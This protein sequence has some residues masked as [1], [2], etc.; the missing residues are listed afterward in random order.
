M[1][2]AAWATIAAVCVVGCGR[3]NPDLVGTWSSGLG[4]ALTT[5]H[6]RKDGTFTIENLY[7]GTRAIIEGTYSTDGGKLNTNPSKADV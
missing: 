3:S 5:Y 7:A 4:G 2:L 1:K 6:F